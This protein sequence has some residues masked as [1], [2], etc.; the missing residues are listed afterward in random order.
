VGKGLEP[1]PFR[2]NVIRL[3]LETFKRS[4]SVNQHP[5]SVNNL[6]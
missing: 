3:T 6:A 1:D 2:A 4:Q 5:K